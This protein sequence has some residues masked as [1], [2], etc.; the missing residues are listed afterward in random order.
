MPGS[1]LAIAI[2]L[3]SGPLNAHASDAGDQGLGKIFE[4]AD[5]NGTIVIESLDG[6]TRHIWNTDR[7][8]KR[9]TAAS[10]FK[11]P[12]TL[13]ALEEGVA[14]N[15]EQ[16][17]KWDGTKRWH[18]SWN[19]DQTLK[20]AYKHSCVWV[21][22]DIARKVGKDRYREQLKQLAYGNQTIGDDV[23][24]FWLDGKLRISA[25]EQLSVIRGIYLE[26]FPYRPE[27]YKTLK[28]IMVA[29]KKPDYTLRAKT[30]WAL[31]TDENV[32][33]YVGYLESGD[34]V[35]VFAANIDMPK[36]RANVIEDQIVM[37]AFLIKGLIKAR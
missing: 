5:A 20:T 37:E 24:T 30:G 25:F 12:N 16:P 34:D 1:F 11:I 17:F 9:F 13:I 21:Y 27:S 33:W 8:K 3:L 22:Q 19:Q 26:E 14:K 28:E 23:S 29:K 32:R 6:K 10:T 2:T 31:R 18:P 7:A 35:W 4:R 36:F 15:A